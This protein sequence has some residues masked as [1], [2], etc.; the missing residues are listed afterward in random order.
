MD[1]IFITLR[2][3]IA[4]GCQ[5]DWRRQKTLIDDYRVFHKRW[6]ESQVR[7][8]KNF[9]FTKWFESQQ[10]ILDNKLNKI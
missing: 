1:K 8:T 2:G 4:N 6:D 3:K 9:Y 7:K 10:I 5:F